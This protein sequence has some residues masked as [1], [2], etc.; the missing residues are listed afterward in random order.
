MKNKRAART[1][2][3]AVVDPTAPASIV[4][5]ER[6]G[7]L[8]RFCEAA[9]RAGTPYASST[10]WGWLKRGDIPPRQVPAI[11]AIASAQ[12]PVVKLRDSDFI[13]QAATA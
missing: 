11:K 6:F 8:A 10:V 5:T 3:A 12:R 2:S 4:I 9:E 7:G 1:S 13:R